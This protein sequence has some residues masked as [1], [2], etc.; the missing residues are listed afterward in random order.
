MTREEMAWTFRQILGEDER[1]ESLARMRCDGLLA[2]GFS[3]RILRDKTII[4]FL[5]NDQLATEYMKTLK[6]L[7]ESGERVEHK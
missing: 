7:I 5:E 6:S 4:N 1:A 2:E 3:G